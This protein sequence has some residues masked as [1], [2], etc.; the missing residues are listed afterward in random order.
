MAAMLAGLGPKKEADKGKQVV[1]LSE[2]CVQKDTPNEIPE[3]R[4][5]ELATSAGQDVS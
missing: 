5:A 3:A 4:L 2:I 1:S